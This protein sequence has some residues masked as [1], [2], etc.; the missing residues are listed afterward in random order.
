MGFTK[1]KVLVHWWDPATNQV[2]HAFAVHFDEH[3]VRL[4]EDEKLS[5][6]SMLLSATAD[7]NM[8]LSEC[9]IN[10]TMSNHILILKF[11]QFNYRFMF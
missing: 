5:P 6:G 11:L 1:S 9:T 10:L 7:K 4:H 3:H 2:K 8:V